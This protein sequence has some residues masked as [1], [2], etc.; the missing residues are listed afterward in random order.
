MFGLF[1]DSCYNCKLTAKVRHK[2][3]ITPMKLRAFRPLWL[4]LL[5]LPSTGPVAQS[6]SSVTP[7]LVAATTVPG[8]ESETITNPRREPE[9]NGTIGSLQSSPGS[10]NSGIHL[11]Q[12]IV[13]IV[14][15]NRTFDSYFG[16]FPGANGATSGE[17]STGQVIPLI[18]QPDRLP[19]DIDHGWQAAINAIDGGKMNGFNLLS[20]GNIDGDY[21]AYT[22]QWQADIPAYWAY[23]QNFVLSDNTFSSLH[24]PSFPNHLYTVAAQS[25]GVISNGTNAAP[26]CDADPDATV[27]VLNTNTNEISDV[28]P[29]FD[30]ETLADLFDA[31]GLSWKYYS[32]PNPTNKA[33]WSPL[34]A[35]KHIRESSLWNTNVPDSQTF[36]SDALQGKLAA[37][38]W[39]VTTPPLSEHPPFSVCEGEN[40]LVQ[41]INAVMQGPEW[42]S[43]AIF[44]TWD[45][46]GGFYDHVPP[47]QVDDFGFGPRVPFIIISPY[48]KKGYISHTLYEFSSVLRFAEE[49]FNLSSLTGRDAVAN[50]MLDSFNFTQTPLPPL[51][52]TPRSCPASTYLSTRSLNFPTQVMGTP[53]PVQ[54]IE[55]ENLGAA[56]LSISSI[57]TSGNY[58]I[59]ANNCPSSLAVSATC[60][61]SIS[62]IP[63]AIGSDN[64]TLTVTDNSVGSPQTVSLAGTGTAVALSP[65]SVAFAN[66]N[67]GTSSAP[68]PVALK[69]NGTAPLTITSI[70]TSDA[71][72]QTNTCIPAGKPSGTIAPGASCTVNVTFTPRGAYK[73]DSTLNI[74]NNG[75]PSPVTVDLSGVGVAPYATVSPDS[76]TF[77]AEAIGE[78]SPPQTI[79]LSNTGSATLTLSSITITG[80]FAQ[81]NTCIPAGVTSATLAPGA[82]CTISVTFKPTAPGSST[83]TLAITDNSGDGQ[84]VSLTGAGQ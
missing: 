80:N 65:G 50:D 23:A 55:V 43:T 51:L 44:L 25:A 46:F 42:N 66:Q 3:V 6:P 21:L 83:G 41:Q 60:T 8:G 58:H 59:E 29:C 17:I 27:E 75:G 62:F 38:S 74:F 9:A 77:A 22:Q 13:F 49:D 73:M 71:F 61:V 76:L 19:S 40:W 31:A 63:Q 36:V 79:N 1:T 12:H 82:S 78:T 5:F 34:D 54:T 33:L 16:T 30:F 56:P 11:I 35:V 48:A 72:T 70:T 15:E 53:S 28:F 32:P 18:H 2:S 7:P 14:R 20:G 47:P 84:R 10:E 26:G 57:A 52:L 39:L 64:G 68:A 69:N 24:G 67:V 45:D 4:F 81:T 37:F